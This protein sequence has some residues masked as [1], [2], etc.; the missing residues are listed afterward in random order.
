MIDIL[1]VGAAFALT[2]FI[3]LWATRDEEKQK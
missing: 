2:G 1:V 3:Y